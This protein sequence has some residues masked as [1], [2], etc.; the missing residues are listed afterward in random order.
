MAGVEAPG[1]ASMS[2]ALELLTEFTGLQ[3]AR[4][5][6]YAQLERGFALFLGGDAEQKDYVTLANSA[7]DSFVLISQQIQ[8]VELGLLSDDVHRPDLAAFVR[9]VQELERDKLTKTIELQVASV[10]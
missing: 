9:K 2:T 5:A 7:R 6:A 8:A 4:S 3:G 10:H 1:D